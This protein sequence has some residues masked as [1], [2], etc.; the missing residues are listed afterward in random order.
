MGYDEEQPSNKHFGTRNSS[1]CLEAFELFKDVLIKIL[2][3]VGI[4]DLSALRHSQENCHL[5]I[6]IVT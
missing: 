4:C 3:N 5:K 2:K 1:F 6:M